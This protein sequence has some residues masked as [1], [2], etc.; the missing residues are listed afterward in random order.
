MKLG[1]HSDRAPRFGGSQLGGHA[2]SSRTVTTESQDSWL[3]GP[4]AI[5]RRM[6]LRDDEMT[7]AGIALS[8]EGSV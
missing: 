8:G 1:E 2:R 6:S 5:E 3:H 4:G 7:V